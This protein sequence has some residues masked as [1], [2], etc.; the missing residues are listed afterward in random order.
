MSGHGV[1][2]P[3]EAHR[4][5][6]PQ[7]PSTVGSMPDAT[8]VS[9]VGS[10]TDSALN[11]TSSANSPTVA[12]NH[13]QR[14]PETASPQRLDAMLD[15]QTMRL[16]LASALQG[17]NELSY[18][19][20][21]M[22]RPIVESVVSESPMAIFDTPFGGNR[23]RN[24]SPGSHSPIATSRSPPDTSVMATP[25]E[26]LQPKPTQ[27]TTVN[28]T[29][30][31]QPPLEKVSLVEENYGAANQ[32]EDQTFHMH[33]SVIATTLCATRLC[34]YAYSVSM[35]TCTHSTHSHSN[36]RVKSQAPCSRLRLKR[37]KWHHRTKPT[38]MCSQQKSRW[39][40]TLVP[41]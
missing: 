13:A 21:H 31:E 15:T 24:A 29:S 8:T 37:L 32:K 28:S 40:L 6:S 39:S 12:E 9:P 19:R 11:A 27:N 14:S 4:L 36:H 25:K 26:S 20:G 18:S 34:S 2:T 35:L 7:T 3:S 30:L 10:A 5:V 38:I 17:H 23:R 16:N 33:V 1:H 22:L 41:Q